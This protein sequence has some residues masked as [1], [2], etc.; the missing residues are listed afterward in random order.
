ME[1]AFISDH[2]KFS[3]D[4]ALRE[5]LRWILIKNDVLIIEYNKIVK[6]RYDKVV[7]NVK[8]VGA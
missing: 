5:M 6:D 1:S 4:N 7:A 2:Y 3:F 8:T